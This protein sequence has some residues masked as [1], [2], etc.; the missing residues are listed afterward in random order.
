MAKTTVDLM[1]NDKM[2]FSTTLDGHKMILDAAGESGGEDR[3]PRPKQLMLVA[4][5]GCTGMDVV[6]ILKKMRVEIDG[7][8]V[9]V[10]GELSEEHPKYYQK[11]H[12]IYEFRGNDL[13]L[14]KLEK[15]VNLSEER[16][17]GVSELYRKAIEI[18][19]EI[20]MIDC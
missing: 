17:C 6:S 8:H 12:V 11:M 1:W 13:P 7:F 18:T 14:G 3:G 2:S 20:R 10:E 9:I 5:A 4:L 19:S 15:A 16:Y